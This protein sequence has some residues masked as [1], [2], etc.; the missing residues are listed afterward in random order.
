MEP[1]WANLEKIATEI[2]EGRRY[3]GQTTDTPDMID[4]LTRFMNL[5]RVSD[6]PRGSGNWRSRWLRWA[7]SWRRRRGAHESTYERSNDP[8]TMGCEASWHFVCWYELEP[9]FC[10]HC[11][12]CLEQDN[13]AASSSSSWNNWRRTERGRYQ[14]YR[15]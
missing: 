7:Q 10:W 12:Y 6:A 1:D 3:P 8:A 2:D 9:A 13:G 14:P 15:P 4:A 11:S 5:L